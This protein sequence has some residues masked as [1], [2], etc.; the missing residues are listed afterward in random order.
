[1][2]EDDNIGFKYGIDSACALQKIGIND[3]AE[4]IAALQRGAGQISANHDSTEISL[5]ALSS[6][7]TT[8]LN[9]LIKTSQEQIVNRS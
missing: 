4:I 2:S 3:T 7:S 6:D 8:S 5:S 1:M 9:R